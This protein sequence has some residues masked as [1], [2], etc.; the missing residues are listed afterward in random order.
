MNQ[1]FDV[2]APVCGG[3]AGRALA[4][5]RLRC[6]TAVVAERAPEVDAYVAALPAGAAAHLTRIRDALHRALPD[7]AETIR[8]GMPAIPVAG[9]EAV[10]FAAWKAH[11]GLYPVPPLG[12][13]LEKEV[14]PLRRAKDSV[15]LRYRDPVPVEL[16]SR[17]AARILELRRG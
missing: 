2:T 14:A 3:P 10:H 16:V 1:T 8:Y 11:A 13:D 15:I 5:V 6:D 17:I 7:G 4:A 9:G 12:G